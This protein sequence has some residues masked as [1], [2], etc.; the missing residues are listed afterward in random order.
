[1]SAQ[2][3]VIV[4]L[5]ATGHQGGGVVR[6]LL[7]S[8]SWTVRAGTRSPASA[9]AQKFLSEEQTD[10]D[11]LVLVSVHTYD[12]ESLR[13]AFRGAYGVFAVTSEAYSDKQLLSEEDMLHEIESGRKMIQAAKDCGVEHF[14]FSSL[15][16]M[17]KA[18]AGRYPK[19]FHMNNK[20]GIETIAREQLPGKCTFIIPGFF[21]T[22]LNWQQ[23]SR[24][25]GDF[26]RTRVLPREDFS[27]IDLGN[28]PGLEY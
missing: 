18:T 8:N 14:V 28:G 21:Y 25:E 4:V 15:P 10:D 16:D 3:K 12:V 23:Y 9:K 22:N 20:H 17:M 19:L 2:R 11:R 27:S 26:F 24:R 1:M 13:N 6:E 7:K 5:G